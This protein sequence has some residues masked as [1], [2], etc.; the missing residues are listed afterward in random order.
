[1]FFAFAIVLGGFVYVFIFVTYL[2][3]CFFGVVLPFCV[4]VI[5]MWF[6]VYFFLILVFYH[7]LF[8]SEFFLY[9]I[10]H[11][12]A[13]IGNGSSRNRCL[14]HRLGLEMNRRAALSF[15]PNT[16][17]LRMVLGY[18]CDFSNAPHPV[19]MA[20]NEFQLDETRASNHA[21]LFLFT[22]KWL[23][24]LGFPFEPHRIVAKERILVSH[25]AF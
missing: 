19:L 25:C 2:F 4:C 3:V 23:I 22:L 8:C 7:L 15:S 1:M 18:Q 12:R 10:L 11:F 16:N 13:I 20:A 5:L 24:L 6:C 14:L 17:T 21:K 9:C